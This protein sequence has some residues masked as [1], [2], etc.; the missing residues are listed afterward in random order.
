[1]I[2]LVS[3]FHYALLQAALIY[4]IGQVGYMVGA[5]TGGIFCDCDW[6]NKASPRYGRVLMLQL[7]QFLFAVVAFFRTQFNWGNA[8]IVTV[9]FFALFFLQG[10][11]PGINRPIVYAV[12]PP[13]LRG[14]AFAVML[15]IVE[16]A[17]WATYDLL[18][19][20]LG[21]KFGLQSVYLAALVVAM[22]AN[23]AVIFVL[24]RTYWPDVQKEQNPQAA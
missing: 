20:F 11:N 9:F 21:Q 7:A 5:F 16:S 8:N 17:G 14:A 4:G 6:V 18:A 12:V 1:V 22:L 13:P 24:Y 19:G 2:Y 15:S 10:L 3:V 23:V